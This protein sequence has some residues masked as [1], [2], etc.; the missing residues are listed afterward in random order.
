M[1]AYK[2]LKRRYGKRIMRQ[3]EEIAAE[4]RKAGLFTD[5]PYDMT[6]DSYAYGLLVKR[7]DLRV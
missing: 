1:W 2:G 5:G 3:M 7:R 4:C 6:G